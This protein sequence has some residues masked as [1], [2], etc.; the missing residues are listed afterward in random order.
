LHPTHRHSERCKWGGT[1]GGVQWPKGRYGLAARRG[2][3]RQ[4]QGL[5]DVR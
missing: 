3:K 2:P 1:G 4:G 5:E